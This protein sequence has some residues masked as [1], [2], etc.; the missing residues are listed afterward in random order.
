[1]SETKEEQVAYLNSID[2]TETALVVVDMQNGFCSDEGGLARAGVDIENQKAIIPNVRRLVDGCRA[3][4]MPIIWA[5]QVH[6]PED[7]TKRRRRI[8]NHHDKR[9]I[10][11][12]LR[13]TDDVEFVDGLV[14]AVLSDDHVFEKHRSSCFYNTNLET[15]LRML[16]VQIVIV[17][18]VNSSYCV[19]STVRDAYFREFDVVV[20]RECVAGS[21]KDLHEA[22]LKNFDIFFGASFSLEEFERLLAARTDAA[23]GAE[24]AAV[25]A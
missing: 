9:G 23:A 6:L 1:M 15:K 4:G 3:V 18:G 20:V 8:P 11:V 17:A 16:G 14:G 5:R 10:T 19:D 13:G 7:A 12:C 21:F 24:P 22:F 2:P 25:N